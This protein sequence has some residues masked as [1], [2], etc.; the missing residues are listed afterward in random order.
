[1]RA[2]QVSPNK[3]ETRGKRGES[4]A[5]LLLLLLLQ[6]DDPATGRA[7]K[8]VWVLASD[9]VFCA[10]GRACNAKPELGASCRGVG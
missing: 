6:V 3:G 9:L 1:M 10:A 4:K 2:Q 7:W 8:P 5:F